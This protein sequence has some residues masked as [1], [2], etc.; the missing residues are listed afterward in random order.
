MVRNGLSLGFVSQGKGRC[1][2]RFEDL[3]QFKSIQRQ[4]WQEATRLPGLQKTAKASLEP[5]A[6][7]KCQR[8]FWFSGQ[9]AD[10]ELEPGSY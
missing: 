7:H 3:E 6:G 2:S 8:R 10:R 9:D 5:R 1:L 4:C